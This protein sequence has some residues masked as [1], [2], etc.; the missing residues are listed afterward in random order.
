MS[1]VQQFYFHILAPT[2]SSINPVL[3][4]LSEQVLSKTDRAL[5]TIDVVKF[6]EYYDPNVEYARLKTCIYEFENSQTDDGR[7]N[8]EQLRSRL[9]AV[10]NDYCFRKREGEALFLA[11]KSEVDARLLEEKLA[12]YTKVSLKKTSDVG[13]QSSSSSPKVVTDIFDGE[14]PEEGNGIFGMLLDGPP[15][16]EVI[17]GIQVRIQDMALPKG[18]TGRTAKPLLLTVVKQ[19]DRL[20]VVSHRILPTVRAGIA[21][22]AA[23]S[24]RWK[25]GF[26]GEWCMAGI[27]GYTVEQAEEYISTVALHGL[28]Y[29]HSGGFVTASTSNVSSMVQANIR[30]FPP[31]FR[32]LWDELEAQRKDAERTENCRIWSLLCDIYEQRRVMDGLVCGLLFW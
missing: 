7:G 18:W 29:P 20:A 2:P 11:K 32:D 9:F 25:S 13:N 16:S 12:G 30:F 24:V 19:L 26:V 23:V 15:E 27:G 3:S 28:S 14:I 17:E 8:L 31:F 10:Q 1:S 4:P 5:P 22:R 21:K 6:D